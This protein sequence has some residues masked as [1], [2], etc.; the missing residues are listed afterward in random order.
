MANRFID[1]LFTAGPQALQPGEGFPS[2]EEYGIPYRHTAES[3]ESLIYLG[4]RLYKDEDGNPQSVMHDRAVGY[5]IRV[6]RYPEA[7]TAAPATQLGG[8]V[9]G[10]LVAA[11]RQCSSMELFKD[12][13]AGVFTHCINRHYSRRL[14]QSVW[15]RFLVKYWDN[16]TVGRRQLRGWFHDIW[17]ELCKAAERSKKPAHKR[18]HHTPPPAGRPAPQP[19]QRPSPPASH[20]QRK[21]AAEQ[22]PR[23]QE[24][25]SSSKGPVFPSALRTAAATDGHQHQ[26][27]AGWQSLL[28]AVE[29]EEKEEACGSGKMKEKAATAN[30][31]K[32]K[33]VSTTRPRGVEMEL[34]VQEGPVED[35]LVV[36]RRTMEAELA[37]P[38]RSSR[39]DPQPTGEPWEKMVTDIMQA[40]QQ[41]VIYI[42]RPVPLQ[43]PTPVP[44][45]VPVPVA[46]PQLCPVPVPVP[47]PI[48]ERTFA[49]IERAPQTLLGIQGQQ[50]LIEGSSNFLALPAP[51]PMHLAAPVQREEARVEVLDE[52]GEEDEGNRPNKRPRGEQ[53]ARVEHPT[54]PE[55]R[56]TTPSPRRLTFP[57]RSAHHT[58]MRKWLNSGKKGSQAANAIWESATRAQRRR[59]FV[60]ASVERQ[61]QLLQLV[62]TTAEQ[63]E[64]KALAEAVWAPKAGSLA[65]AASAA[66]RAACYKALPAASGGANWETVCGGIERAAEAFVAL[67]EPTQVDT[68]SG[69]LAEATVEAHTTTTPLML[70]PPPAPQAAEDASNGTSPPRLLPPPAPQAIWPVFRQLPQ[71]QGS[72]VTRKSPGTEKANAGAQEGGLTSPLYGCAPPEST[73]ASHQPNSE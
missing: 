57:Q 10:R 18:A 64:L 15:N 61:Q 4:V 55:G 50:H 26:E 70:L 38:P 68:P 44:I 65:E 54:Q 9:M 29:E 51:Q 20:L 11:Q 73:Q 49:V 13:V 42:D 56:L 41:R 25:A 59:L 63:M 8:V 40:I 22:Q 46:V 45:Q 5:P 28:E 36:M 60:A 19:Q 6:D 48:T 52:E 27:D 1:D 39:K 14:V 53:M 24:V 72:V 32:H 33:E 31:P 62:D 58:P 43:V 69:V 71:R 17:M 12:A 2:A 34:D 67:F 16:A 30:R 7:G 21:Q 35:A 37:Q 23:G 3:S 66:L 47:I